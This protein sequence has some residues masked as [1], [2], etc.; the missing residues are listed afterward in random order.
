MSSAIVRLEFRLFRFV[1]GFKNN[2]SNLYFHSFDYFYLYFL[3]L[4]RRNSLRLLQTVCMNVTRKHVQLVGCFFWRVCPS[5]YFFRKKCTG[6][7]KLQVGTTTVNLFSLS[8]R[9]HYQHAIFHRAHTRSSK[10]RVVDRAS[11][12]LKNLL[13]N[14][15]KSL[16]SLNKS[17]NK[18]SILIFI[19][20]MLQMTH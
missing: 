1:T 11:I 16:K 2:V 14:T 20:C 3:I 6:N 7:E 9:E 15:N 12:L 17:T 19:I 10:D 8:C 13:K 18:K 5:L 4:K